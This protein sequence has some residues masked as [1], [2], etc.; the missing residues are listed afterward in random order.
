[1]FEEYGG[2]GV[3]CWFSFIVFEEFG[4]VNVSGSGFVLYFDIVVFYILNYGI[5]D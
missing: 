3:D 4:G 1:M 2:V 5:L